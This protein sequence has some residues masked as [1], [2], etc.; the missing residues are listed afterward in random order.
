MTND[1]SDYRKV[2]ITA[3]AQ[4]LVAV[5]AE[6]AA[7]IWTAP[8]DGT[9]EPRRISAGRYDGISG[10]AAVP[11]GR[12]LFRT[13]DNG[14]NIWITNED[15]S[16]RTQLT[17]EGF[18]GWPVAT[19]DARSM[20]YAR[21]GSGLWQIGLDGQGARSIPGTNG[22]MYPETTRNGQSIIF[23]SQQAGFEQLAR[24]PIGGGAAVA[25]LDYFSTRPSVSPDGTQ[26]A[27]YFRKDNKR[28]IR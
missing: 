15:G 26:V 5:A 14:S 20:I 2:S 7:S 9:S 6:A 3:D 21:E 18:V 1:Q 22:G 19:A 25:M 27:F 13:V 23:V 24:I 4:S 10:V 12:I 17:T 28:R 11:G 8:T 16:G